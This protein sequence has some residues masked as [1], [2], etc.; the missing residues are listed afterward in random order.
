M[1]R[2]EIETQ[3]GEDLPFGGS[4][5]HVWDI[6]LHNFDHVSE[7]LAKHPYGPDSDIADKGT[8]CQALHDQ[9]GGNW[10]WSEA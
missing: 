10:T 9:Y 8:L 2:E 7:Y 3:T 5:F 4:E 1:T 6:S